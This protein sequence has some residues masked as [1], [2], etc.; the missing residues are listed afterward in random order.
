MKEKLSG[1]FISV[2]TKYLSAVETDP[3]H[4]HQHEINGSSHLKDIF[5]IDR[6]NMKNVPFLYLAEDEEDF[7]F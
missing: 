5:G 4:S 1:Y 6:R 3:G 7:L 2:A